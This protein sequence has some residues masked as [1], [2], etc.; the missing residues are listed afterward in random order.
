MSFV[1]DMLTT[2]E[3][4]E[5]VR[6]VR[7]DKGTPGLFVLDMP[8]EIVSDFYDLKEHVRIA[9]AHGRLNALAIA[10]SSRGEG[11]STIA[12]FLAFLMSDALSRSF[13][14][15]Y[16]ANSQSVAAKNLCHVS[17]SDRL[18]TARFSQNSNHATTDDVFRDWNQSIDARFAYSENNSSVLLVDA[19]LHN[20][21][22]HN[23][24]GLDCRNGLAE[25]LEKNQNWRRMVL[26]VRDSHLQILKAGQTKTN[27]VDLLGSDGFREL[28]Q[29]W[30][31]EYRYVIFDSPAVLNY[32]D[33]LSLAATVDGVVLVVK[34]GQTRWDSA[35]KAKQKLTSVQ[36]NLLGVTLNRRKMDIPDG[37]Y[38]R[39]I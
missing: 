3:E 30:K 32:V 10:D 15:N 38:K 20:P 5:R 8:N 4:K 37:L 7:R 26:P 21:S 2:V 23:Y 12:T 39:M 34:A 16:S 14:H 17:E 35:Q 1:H 29:E 9:N 18:F 19:N 25:I 28:V 24:F 6:H 11:S 36:A 27:P 31:N 22:I 33:A 13:N